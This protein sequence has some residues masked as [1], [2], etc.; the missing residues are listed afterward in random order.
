MKTWPGFRAIEVDLVGLP[1]KGAPADTWGFVGVAFHVQE[2]GE[3]F[4]AMYLRF[5]NGRAEDQLRRNHATQYVSEPEYPWFRLRKENPGVYESY[6][7]IE[8]EAWTH[9][10][11][12]VAGT[13]A[14]LYVNRSAQPC[15]IV[16]DL[17]LG[18]TAAGWRC[19]TVRTRKRIFPTCELTRANPKVGTVS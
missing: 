2:S 19:E 17:K 11:V 18:E 16:T 5:T 7:E 12:E 8:P 4:E 13:T 3:R 1:R 9:L 6:G 10:R 15:L 14:R